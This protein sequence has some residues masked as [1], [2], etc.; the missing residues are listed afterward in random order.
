MD[1]A[2][3]IILKFTL[4]NHGTSEHVYNLC[5]ALSKLQNPTKL[6]NSMVITKKLFQSGR[7]VSSADLQQLCI[8]VVVGIGFVC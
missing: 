2:P 7:S 3:I 8:G 4:E 5:F 6:Q 1:L